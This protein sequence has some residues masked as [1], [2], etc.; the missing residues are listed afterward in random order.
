MYTVFFIR[1]HLE[2]PL[3]PVDPTGDD[4]FS[5]EELPSFRGMKL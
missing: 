2:S 4:D 3:A 5:E 1:S